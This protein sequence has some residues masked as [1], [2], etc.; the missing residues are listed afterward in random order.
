M[1]LIMPDLRVTPKQDLDDAKEVASELG[2]ET[3]FFDIAPI[4]RTFMKNLEPNRL[5]EGNLRARIR[6]ALLYFY[7]NSTNRLVAGTG[8]RSEYLLSYYTK[9]GDGGVDILPIGDLYKTEVRRLGETLGVSRRIISKRSSPRL[10]P[11]QDA[12]DELGFSYDVLDS[13]FKLYFDRRLGMKAVS[14]RLKLDLDAVQ[15]LISRYHETAH[16]RQPPPICK[17]R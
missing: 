15:R 11:G 5:A 10:W 16:K 3:G 13:V 9:F 2:M 6:M 17:L 8:D 14:S 7:A 4:H 1:G 12:E